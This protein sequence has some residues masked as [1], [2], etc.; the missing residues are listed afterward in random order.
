MRAASHALEALLESDLFYIAD[1]YTITLRD[2]SV[3]RY[4]SYDQPLSSGGNVFAVGP[5]I[6]KSNTSVKIGY[7]VDDETVVIYPAATDK[8]A[9]IPI[10]TRVL[11]GDFDGARI[12]R[13]R[14]FMPNAIDTSAGTLVMFVGRVSTVELSATKIT[15]TVRSD[16][17]LLDQ[18]MPRNLFQ[19]SCIHALFDAG[20]TLHKATY[21]VPCE[22]AAD[23]TPNHVTIIAASFTSGVLSYTQGTLTFTSGVLQGVSVTIAGV[24]GAAFVLAYPLDTLPATGDTFN[25]YPGC[26]KTTSACF[27]FNNTPNF[28]GF[29]YIPAVTTA[30]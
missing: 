28:R 30:V 22:V 4:T 8:I 29:P 20:C 11:A 14:A 1:L 15:L 6:E 12:S 25:V 26:N 7:E 13:E 10:M 21:A 2:G 18:E 16:L 24:F 17:Y 23:G 5:K 9:G 3:H 27:I 19:A